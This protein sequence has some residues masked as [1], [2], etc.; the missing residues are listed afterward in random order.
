[1]RAKH[2]LYFLFFINLLVSC[3]KKNVK[4]P[5]IEIDGIKEIQNHSSIWIFYKLSEE[6]IEADLNKNNKLLNT[7]W[8]YNIDRRLTMDKIAPILEE[9]QENRKKKSMH[10]IEGM[11]NYF[12][13]ANVVSQN[14]SLVQF[15]PI[16]FA[17]QD[18]I[19]EIISM[20]S[21]EESFIR[22]EITNDDLHIDQNRIDPD[23][24][25]YR[26]NSILS[27]DTLSS[28][29]I[30]L[31]YP[32][33]LTYQNYLSVKALL[34]ELKLKMDKNEYIYTIK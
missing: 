1:M 13:Y 34:S 7:H 3:D 19:I 32:G 12:S 24:L 2:L 10:K 23:R 6:G 5:L 9:M 8:I 22:L 33:N 15:D 16:S 26:L 28:P 14:I 11:L 4:L 25:Q 30:I 18:K 20:E 31:Q 27:K 29:K 21:P 17:Y